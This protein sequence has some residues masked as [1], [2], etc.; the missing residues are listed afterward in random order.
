MTVVIKI[1]ENHRLGQYMGYEKDK[2]IAKEID[3][4]A[5]PTEVGDDYEG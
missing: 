2:E 1:R 4:E 5:S 3:E